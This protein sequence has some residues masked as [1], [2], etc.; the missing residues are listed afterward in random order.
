M[1][2]K[3]SRWF[4]YASIALICLFNAASFLIAPFFYFSGDMRVT[5]SNVGCAFFGCNDVTG[6]IS[7]ELL[8]ANL[9]LICPVLVALLVRSKFRKART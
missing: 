1:M 9:V 4:L 5:I 8:L 6:I 7:I 3:A 2:E